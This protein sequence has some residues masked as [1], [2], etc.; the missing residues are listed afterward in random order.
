MTVHLDTNLLI[1]LGDTESNFSDS[2]E[3]WI[4]EGNHVATSSIAWSEF[5][6]GPITREH[7]DA[8]AA[9]L[10]DEILDFSRAMAERTAI[11]FNTTGRRRGS[12]SDCM[13]AACAM[14]SNSPLATLNSQDFERFI[15][16]GLLLHDIGKKGTAI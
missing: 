13:I 15:P 6:N 8:V 16:M 9:V 12:H 2:L 1:A 4:I 14:V 11:L 5:C 3:R 10:R 7:K